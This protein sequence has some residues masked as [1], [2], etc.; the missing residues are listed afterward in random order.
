[1]LDCFLVSSK[2]ELEKELSNNFYSSGK[3][4]IFSCIP[5]EFYKMQWL[6]AFLNSY[7]VTAS[8]NTVV[9]SLQ[10]HRLLPPSKQAFTS[11][12]EETMSITFA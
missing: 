9:L 12:D 11:I 3:H 8:V 2:S 1:M 6:N 10:D 4:F 7:I 5:G